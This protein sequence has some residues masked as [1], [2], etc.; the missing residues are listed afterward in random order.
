[1]KEKIYSSKITE[2]DAELIINK[3]SNFDQWLATRPNAT[4][5]RLN[6]LQFSKDFQLSEDISLL[7]FEFAQEI[8]LLKR[9]YEVLDTDHFEV[10]GVYYNKDD[11]K[12]SEYSYMND[13]E[14][15]INPEDINIW[16]K[17]IEEPIGNISERANQIKKDTAPPL[18]LSNINNSDNNLVKKL[19]LR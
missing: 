1:M 11:L 15:N 18:N 6:P 19:L 10:L 17:L 13:Q 8:G 3:I 4:I 12:K 5:H 2:Q 16:F 9:Y 14:I 7:L